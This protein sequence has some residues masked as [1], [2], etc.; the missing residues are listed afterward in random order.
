MLVFPWLACWGLVSRKRETCNCFGNPRH[1]TTHASNLCQAVRKI[2]SK[3][4]VSSCIY[5]HPIINTI[6]IPFILLDKTLKCHC[7][8]SLVWQLQIFN[9]GLL[10]PLSTFRRSLK[11]YRVCIHDSAVRGN[12]NWKLLKCKLYI[13]ND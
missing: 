1:L 3:F 10:K 8:S 5:S 6:K 9:I 4:Q 2:N 11:V 7:V 12:E 13:F